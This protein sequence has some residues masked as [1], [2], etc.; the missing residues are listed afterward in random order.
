MAIKP[1]GCDFC[2]QLCEDNSRIYAYN[3][4]NHQVIPIGEEDRIKK[5]MSDEDFHEF[6]KYYIS[7]CPDDYFERIAAVGNM[8][9]QT[10]RFDAGDIFRCQVDRTHYAYG[11]ILGKTRQIEKWDEL[12]EEHSFRHVMMQPIIVRMYD[13]VTTDKNMTDKELADK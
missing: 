4:R 2:I 11:L 7:T 6:M 10:I 1:F 12:P 3:M 9:H 5:I 13:F 8:E